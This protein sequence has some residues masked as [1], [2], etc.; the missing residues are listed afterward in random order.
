VDKAEFIWAVD[1]VFDASQAAVV[2]GARRFQQSRDQL[3]AR[4]ADSRSILN[5]PRNFGRYAA[6]SVFHT[7]PA[8]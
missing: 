5:S 2:T 1:D 4:L 8:R 6:D 7:L 3:P